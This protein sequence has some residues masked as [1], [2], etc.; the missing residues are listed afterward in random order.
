MFELWQWLK[1]FKTDS[2]NRFG[3][4]VNSTSALIPL[5]HFWFVQLGWKNL[6]SDA[7]EFIHLSTLAWCV[8]VR[9]KNS[10]VFSKTGQ[11]SRSNDQKGWKF[12]TGWGMILA[13]S[14]RTWIRTRRWS[15]SLP[16]GSSE[17]ACM[18]ACSVRVCACMC[19]RVWERMNW[20]N[21]PHPHF[22]C[23]HT[24]RVLTFGRTC[25]VSARFQR[26]VSNCFARMSIR[27][28][29]TIRGAHAA[30]L[31]P[32]DARTR[33]AKHSKMLTG[34]YFWTPY[35]YFEHCQTT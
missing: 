8:T 17:C 24:E 3:R 2:R 25:C 19:E 33:L 34:P 35:K 27:I 7:H 14:I 12:S 1:I 13:S 30:P 6:L 26:P 15:T 20:W 21:Y 16:F 31:R 23:L 9:T 29:R 28:N 4:T 5:F 11:A 32:A 22:R 18:Y 10:P